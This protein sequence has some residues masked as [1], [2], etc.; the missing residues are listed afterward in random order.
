MCYD[1]DANVALRAL[2]QLHAAA[3]DR[4][5]VQAARAVLTTARHP[6]QLT[7]AGYRH[8]VLRQKA[9]EGFGP[10]LLLPATEM[11][12]RRESRVTL[13][14]RVDA[15]GMPRAIV[16]WRVG[17]PEVRTAAVFAG[18]LDA[19]LRGAALGRLALSALPRADELEGRV[20]GGCH[21]IGT[22]R[23]AADA[24]GGVVDRDC[25]VFGVQN[26]FIAGSAVFPTSGWSNP[27]LTLLALGYRLADQLK[28]E[29][30]GVAPQGRK[31]L[32]RRGGRRM[33]HCPQRNRGWPT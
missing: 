7:A 32:A 28:S 25:R 1:P 21:H 24:R 20:A 5:P 22:T 9:S 26:L 18:R 29:L 30:G 14:H 31:S 13:D 3:R 11:V 12:A 6:R 27:T 8:T 10:I 23:M 17:R 4:R 15:L 2:K 19:L 16:D 33:S